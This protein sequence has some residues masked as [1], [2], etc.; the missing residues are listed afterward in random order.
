VGKLREIKF[1]W[2][3][4]SAVVAAIALVFSANQIRE[5]ADAQSQTKRATE[6]GLLTELQSVLSQSTYQR[7]PYE[8]QFVELRAGKRARLSPA[9]YRAA[10][11]EAANMDYVA[12]LFNN[13]YLKAQDAEQL[14]GPRMICEYKR[15]FAP[16]FADASL[17]ISN[18]FEFVRQR[19]SALVRLASCPG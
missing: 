4:L 15:V 2:T 18:L 9:A 13:G 3:A 16:A 19:S 11:E 17:D 5:G 1:N 7:V 8:R 6:L 10:A 12:W 14:W